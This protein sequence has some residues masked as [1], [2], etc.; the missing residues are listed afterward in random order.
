MR[1]Q[2]R[3]HYPVAQLQK[4]ILEIADSPGGT[5]RPGKGTNLFGKGPRADGAFPYRMVLLPA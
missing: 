4:A 3:H 1:D 2:N 5:R